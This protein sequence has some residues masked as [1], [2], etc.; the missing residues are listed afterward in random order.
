MHI[1]IIHTYPTFSNSAR[2]YALLQHR[3]GYSY[4]SRVIMSANYGMVGID[5][6]Y[7]NPLDEIEKGCFYHWKSTRETTVIDFRGFRYI[8][9]QM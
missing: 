5:D 4:D 8:M 1:T 7:L 2:V 9:A 6:V 3:G